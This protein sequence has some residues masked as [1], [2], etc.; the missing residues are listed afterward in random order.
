MKRKDMVGRSGID[1]RQITGYETEGTW[2]ELKT[3]LILLET[4]RGKI[5]DIEIHDIFDFTETRR[6]RHSFMSLEE[7]LAKRPHRPDRDQSDC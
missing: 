6:Y 4:F 3:L 1:Y 5:S 2:P 7:R